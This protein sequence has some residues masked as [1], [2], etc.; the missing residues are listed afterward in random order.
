MP[1]LPPLAPLLFLLT[2]LARFTHSL[3][4]HQLPS[5]GGLTA[6]EIS[7]N[8]TAY[9]AHTISIPIDHYNAS[10]TRKYQNR[11]WINDEYYRRGGPVFYFDAGEQNAH[12]LVPYFLHEAAGPSAVMALARRFNGLAVLFEHRFYGD[13]HEGSF[14]FAMN[15]TSGLAEGGFAAYRYLTTEQAL[16]D[17]VY[18]AEHFQPPGTTEHDCALL[19]PERT[20]WVWLGGSYPGIRGAHMRVRNP[21]TFYAAWASSAPTEAA[22]DMWTYYAQAERSMTRNCSADYTAV[23]RYVDATLTNGTE[24]EVTAMKRALYEAVLSGPRGRAPAS[25]NA[26]DVAALTNSDIASYLLLPLSFY[27]YYGFERSVLP[28]CDIVETLNQTSARTTDNG[29]TD[30]AIATESGIA[31]TYNISLAWSA[32]LTGIAE[33]D[34]DSVPYHDDPI[35]DR[36]WMWQYCSEYGYYQR[37]NPDNP[38]TVE[39]RFTSLD[40]FQAGCNSTFPKGLPA[41]PNVTE[42]NKYGGWHINPSN[43]MF[44]SGEYDPWRALSPAS[45]EFGSPNRTTTQDIPECGVPPPNDTVF[46]IVYRDMVHVSDMRALLN[47]SDVNH[48][49]FSTVGFSSPISTEPFYAGEHA[50]V[51]DQSLDQRKNLRERVAQ[52]EALVTRLLDKDPSRSDSREKGAAEALSHMRSIDGTTGRSGSGTCAGA[53]PPTPSPYTVATPAEEFPEHAPLL[54]MFNNDVLS[55]TDTRD[56]QCTAD[57]PSIVTPGSDLS[58]HGSNT[59]QAN[60]KNAR[61]CQELL[62][63]LPT[64]EDLFKIIE[65]TGG[66]WAFMRQEYPGICGD[67]AHITF[68]HFYARA[69]RQGSPAV[70]GCLLLCMAMSSHEHADVYLQHVDALVTSDDAYAGTLD[71]IVCMILQGKCY[72]NMGQPRKSWLVF[73]RGI[74]FAQLM[75]LHR[76]H[77]RPRKHESIWWQ[78]YMGDRYLSILLG[79]PHGITDSHCDLT[80]QLDSKD[81]WNSLLVFHKRTAVMAGK[82]IDRTQGI[83][84][85]SYASAL[86]IDQQLDNIENDMPPEWWDVATARQAGAATLAELHSRLLTQI[87]AHQIRL[88]L[89]LPF[90]LKSAN[91]PR[92][93][94]SRT[95]CFGAA[96]EMLRIYHLLTVEFA[97]LS[98]E[99][100]VIDFIAFTAAVLLVLGLLGYG[101]LDSSNNA[102]QEE[103]DW[104]LI[105][106]TLE[107]FRQASTEKEPGCAAHPNGTAKIAIPYFGTIS[108]GRGRGFTNVRQTDSTG[109]PTPDASSYGQESLATNTPLSQQELNSFTED[110]LITYDG[111]YMSANP[112]PPGQQDATGG[113]ENA[114]SDPSGLMWQGVPNADIDQDWSWFMD[115]VQQNL[116]GMV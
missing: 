98:Y 4:L 66:W 48:Q 69:T 95:A 41:S 43:T 8:V 20:P 73:R 9:P 18:F 25:V 56:S 106:I 40:L 44:S 76:G 13:L 81:P 105:D 5:N 100:K 90:M 91:N 65:R 38:H 101:R 63:L 83:A 82:V 11:Y 111:F 57:E 7:V 14:P 79:L 36:S 89:H 52:L 64:R 104:A 113:F 74:M 33:I 85:Q 94:Y 71:G 42:P 53:F 31:V 45:T 54:S 107:I 15:A 37:G 75:G 87:C 97:P 10:D 32:F 21:G 50:E 110:P 108:V 29:G 55:R 1:S 26:S 116:S 19:S 68:Q 47:T 88:Y 114:F 86:D 17:V 6:R 49:N 112:L 24:G 96:R 60:P 27:Q 99:C 39:S 109:L 46:G 23:T 77:K 78:L 102:L 70:I 72:G 80:V 28:F 59:Q 2:I 93:G 16:Q 3:R 103:S 92:Y 67:D 84:D 61:I 58:R 12:P 62:S 30:P 51:D 34:Y 22:V 115:P 35:Q